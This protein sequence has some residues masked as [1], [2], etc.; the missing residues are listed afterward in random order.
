MA[1]RQ[2]QFPFGI[3]AGDVYNGGGQ[4]NLSGPQ[5]GGRFQHMGFNFGQTQSPM[6]PQPP[7]VSGAAGF[8]HFSEAN[9]LLLDHGSRRNFVRVPAFLTLARIYAVQTMSHSMIALLLST[10]VPS[11]DPK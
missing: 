11:L 6:Q 5:V 1:S 10:R 3:G 2:Q 7:S 4:P 9:D 8:Q